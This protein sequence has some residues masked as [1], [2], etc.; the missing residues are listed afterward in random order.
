MS[1][2]AYP[3]SPGSLWVVLCTRSETASHHRSLILHISKRPHTAVVMWL[4]CHCLSAE[5]DT[6]REPL[7]LL[8]GDGVLQRPSSNPNPNQIWRLPKVH[9]L[10][11]AN[12]KR[13]QFLQI[14][15]CCIL[16]LAGS[17]VIIEELGIMGTARYRGSCSSLPVDKLVDHIVRQ[18]PLSVASPEAFGAH[19]TSSGI[20]G[21]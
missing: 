10:L 5:L 14:S 4:C 3:A 12:R 8:E 7:R 6:V 19:R 2:E 18:R 21:H 11:C 13:T 9:P 15:L 1:R 16:K 17:K 20:A